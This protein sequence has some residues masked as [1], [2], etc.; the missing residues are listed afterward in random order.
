MRFELSAAYFAKRNL[1]GGGKARAGREFIF[2]TPLFLPAPPER[3]KFFQR[4]F[5]QSLGFPTNR[6]FRRFGKGLPRGFA[7]RHSGFAQGA[8]PK[9]PTAAKKKRKWI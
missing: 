2:P 3:Q 7:A 4:N 5:E 6:N 8:K 1:T 9:N